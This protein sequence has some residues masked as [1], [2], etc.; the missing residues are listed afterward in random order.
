MLDFSPMSTPLLMRNRKEKEKRLPFKWSLYFYTMLFKWNGKQKWSIPLYYHQGSVHT[1][2]YFATFVYKDIAYLF[3]D[4]A[5]NC[6]W[7][8]SP[9]V[10]L[11]MAP[12]FS[13][14][15]FLL[16]LTCFRTSPAS[17][18]MDVGGWMLFRMLGLFKGA[19]LTAIASTGSGGCERGGKIERYWM[20][21][22]DCVYFE[23]KNK[24]SL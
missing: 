10:A 16:C 11:K 12:R 21:L 17:S 5:S 4:S 22:N 23:G 20:H 3:F 18:N 13:S 8:T 15:T 14:R 9:S 1:V 7:S 2:Q 19:A 24:L 6:V